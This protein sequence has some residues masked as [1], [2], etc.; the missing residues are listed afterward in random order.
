MRGEEPRVPREHIPGEHLTEPGRARRGLCDSQ[1]S[2]S[3]DS[4]WRVTGSVLTFKKIIL[5]SG[6]KFGGR[7]MNSGLTVGGGGNGTGET[8]IFALQR[9]TAELTET[10]VFDTVVGSN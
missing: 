2:Y 7:R 4:G 10:Q 9:I 8:E 5:E 1:E 3:R 6:L